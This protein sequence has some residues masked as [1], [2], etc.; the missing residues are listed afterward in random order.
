MSIDA[1]A[2]LSRR[3]FVAAAAALPLT[4]LAGK[5]VAVDTRPA[6][7]MKILRL[8]W[9]GIRLEVGDVSLFV[10]AVAPDPGAKPATPA[11]A[12]TLGRRFAL[13]THHHGDHCDPAALKSV[14][15]DNGYLVAY[16]ETARLFD[17]RIVT[18]EPARLYEPVL[19][20]RIRGEFVAW[21]VGAADG[22]GG[23]QVSWIVDGGGR[24][25]IH[26]GD[27]AWHS[28]WWTTAR[29][30]G[31]FDIA[32][33]PIN[34]FRQQAGLFQHIEQPMSLTPEQAVQ[35]GKILGAREVVPIHYGNGGNP[36]Y[37]EEPRA[38]VRFTEAARQAGLAVRAMAP[39][40]LVDLA[41]T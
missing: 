3:R 34:G 16:E 20:S 14:L 28:G 7:G 33:L 4:T 30:Y 32:F 22:L 11:L 21:C 25:I 36:D 41:S 18:V 29:A 37:V 38:L 12:S 35:A 39:G 17:N 26:C 23:P 27:T 5:A 2:G 10:D 8:G 15:G 40:D 31:P 19:L 13:V 1:T 6:A 9:A 24:R